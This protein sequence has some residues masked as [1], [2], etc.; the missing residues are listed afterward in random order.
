MFEVLVLRIIPHIAREIF[1]PNFP[2]YSKDIPAEDFFTEYFITRQGN[3]CT[4]FP[5]F[6]GKFP[7]EKILPDNFFQ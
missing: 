3:S 2:L 4:L 6:H 7:R 1:A 5:F